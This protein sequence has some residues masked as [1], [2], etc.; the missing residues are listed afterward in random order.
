MEDLLRVGENSPDVDHA[1]TDSKAIRDSETETSP[2]PAAGRDAAHGHRIL[3]DKHTVEGVDSTVPSLD[4]R[5]DS[6]AITGPGC[7]MQGDVAAIIDESASHTGTLE[8]FNEFIGD[9]AGYRGH[10]RNEAF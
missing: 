10:R 4:L 8:P 7:K 6:D 2:A 5:P 9:S 3:D 1:S